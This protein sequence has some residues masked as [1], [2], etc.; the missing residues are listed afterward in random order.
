MEIGGIFGDED[1]VCHK[2][3]MNGERRI[4]G[5]AGISAYE[6]Y[7]SSD[8]CVRKFL[9]KGWIAYKIIMVYIRTL[10]PQKACAFKESTH[11][12]LCAQCLTLREKFFHPMIYAGLDRK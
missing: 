9:L 4:I 11:E 2:Q 1:V 8:D 7:A 5:T 3:L 10:I 12:L 6:F